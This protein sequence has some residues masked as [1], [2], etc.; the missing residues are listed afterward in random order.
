MHVQEHI[1]QAYLL[2][3][4]QKSEHI[5]GSVIASAERAALLTDMP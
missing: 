3:D 4:L 2:R 5:S 1:F